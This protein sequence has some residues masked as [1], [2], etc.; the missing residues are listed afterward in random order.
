MIDRTAG[1]ETGLRKNQNRTEM[2]KVYQVFVLLIIMII[3]NP[4]VKAESPAPSPLIGI[5][6]VFSTHA[7]WDNET[8]SCVDRKR[9]WC[10]RLRIEI[11]SN[12]SNGVITGEIINQPSPGINLTI[13]KKTGITPET[14]SQYFKDG[15]FYLDGEGTIQPELAKKLN[16]PKDYVIPEGYYNYREEGDLIIISFKRRL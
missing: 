1:G 14:Y 7:R 5:T 8:E 3:A 13:N 16:L 10:L 11:K 9:G 2:K 4:S 15:K 6:I 12:L